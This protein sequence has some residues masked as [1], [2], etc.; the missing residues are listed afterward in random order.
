MHRLAHLLSFHR[1][2]AWLL[3]LGLLAV[4]LHALAVTGLMR[5]GSGAG[6]RGGLVGQVC[7]THG[8]VQLERESAGS[9]GSQPDSGV[10]DC[11]K[12]CAAASPLLVAHSE[13]GVLPAA[14]FAVSGDSP[15][16]APPTAAARTAHPPRGPP[17]RS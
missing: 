13:I 5:A 16:S 10:H 3:A 11:C 14:A 6:N 4:S 17:A 15:S 8:V 9:G 2:A 1:R 12:L 7:T